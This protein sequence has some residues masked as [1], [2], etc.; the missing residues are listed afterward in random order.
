MMQKEGRG[1]F[2]NL[3]SIFPNNYHAQ[4]KKYYASNGSDSK[5]EKEPKNKKGHSSTTTKNML[6]IRS[7]Q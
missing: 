6:G 2:S 4:Y 7:I 3:H 1:K 5:Y